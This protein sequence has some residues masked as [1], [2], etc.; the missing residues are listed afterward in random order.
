MVDNDRW[1]RYS[2]VVGCGADG[3]LLLSTTWRARS[4]ELKAR[5]YYMH[6]CLERM[7]R[8]LK[9]CWNA[10]E[11]SRIT[12]RAL[13]NINSLKWK[14]TWIE[15]I[16][17]MPAVYHEFCLSPA[18]YG[19]TVDLASEARTSILLRASLQTTAI[20]VHRKFE[21]FPKK[22]NGRPWVGSSIEFL[23]PT[24]LHTVIIRFT[25]HPRV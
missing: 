5:R 6:I 15:Q 13:F 25:D 21:K 12:T 1:P 14:G 7:R 10:E 22:T 19:S 3:M 9:D 16:F 8:N 2:Y 11:L 18:R 4:S 23:L 20:E 24:I 17:F